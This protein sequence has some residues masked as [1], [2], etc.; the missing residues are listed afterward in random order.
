[1][2]ALSQFEPEIGALPRLVK[3]EKPQKSQKL[4]LI[5]ENPLHSI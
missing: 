2:D 4:G 5:E 1:M 3:G